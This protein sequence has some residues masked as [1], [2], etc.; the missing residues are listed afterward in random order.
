VPEAAATNRWLGSGSRLH[1]FQDLARF[2]VHDILLVASLYDAFILTEDGQPT[3]G[4]LGRFLSFEP[5][6]APRLRHAATGAEA[7]RLAATEGHFD[8]VIAGVQLGDM[9]VVELTRRLREAGQTMP[10]VALAYDASDLLGLPDDAGALDRVFLWQGD[11][12]ILPAI[13]KYVEDRLNVAADTGEMGVPAIILIEDSVRYYSSF[14]PVI[15][16]ELMRHARSLVPEGLNLS[17]KL[18]RQ[19][20][21]PKILLCRTFEEAW[22][23][24]TAYQDAILGV[25]ADIEFPKGGALA[26]EAGVE[27]ARRVRELQPDVPIMLQSS[28]PENASLAAAVPA[29]FLL[30]DSPTL[31][32]ELQRFMVD[33]FGFGEFIFRTADGTIVG[34]AADLRTLEAELHRVPAESLA[35]HG[36][37]NHFSKWLKARTEFAL[38]HRLRPRTVGDFASLEHLRRDLIAAIH[39]YRQRRR[40]GIVA[41]FDPATFDAETSFCRL[42]SGSLGG[43]GRGLAFLSFLL[44]EYGLPAR[45]APVDLG[46]PPAV[47]LGTD[48][49]DRVLDASDLRDAALASGDDRAVLDRLRATPLPDDV[50]RALARFLEVARY[51]LAVRSSSLL[52]DSPYQPFAGVY[53]T[54]MV[55]NRGDLGTRL[56]HLTEAIRRVYASTF[57]PRVRAYLAASPYRHEEE[58]MAVVIQRVAGR[59]RGDRYYPDLAGV[60]RSH[61]FYAVPPLTAHDGIAAVGLGL[62]ATVVGGDTCFRFSPKHPHHVIQF[63]SVRDVLQNSQRTFYALRLGGRDEGAADMTFDLEPY[64]LATAER[65][66]SLAAVG[67]TYSPENDA[68]FDGIARPGVRLVSFAP[69]LK[70]G[71]FPL[72]DLV[73]ELL[74]I[75]EQGVGGPVELEFAANLAGGGRP[76]EFA[77]LQV[78][79]LAF[80]RDTA[81]LALDVD[82]GST[83]LCRSDL[84]LGH[85]RVDD[86]RDL[87]V[88]DPS[89]VGA[90]RSQEIATEI[91]RLNAALVGAGRPYVLIAVGRL[92]SSEP[93]LGVPVV[94]DQIA[95]ARAIVEAGFRDFKVTPSQGSHFFQ[96]LMTFRVGYFTVN[97]EAGEGF[98]DWDW[99]AAQPAETTRAGVRH[100]RLD[101]PLSIRMNGQDHRGVMTVSATPRVAPAMA[102]RDD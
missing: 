32:H 75:S 62:G 39:E 30:K 4:V 58:K 91:G 26:P 97:P 96:H 63:S 23:D 33:N 29:S 87:V 17:D 27:F 80:S 44:E 99:L 13:V 100:L 53:D 14:L 74:T 49:F 16:T 21:R 93:T 11:V 89:R 82:A 2:R 45:F 36:E 83:L 94:W 7:V 76:A 84:V 52:E 31:L 54:V 72:A 34:R 95:G 25:I 71:L 101:A 19:Q 98:L 48:V 47:V 8:L 102:L 20:A 81:A 61:N 35:F 3:E 37:R 55:P 73:A 1:G 5:H 68:V 69:I 79:P 57:T 24:F 64:D 88:L 92:G 40:R 18:M 38:A 67:S 51:P 60:A 85:G 50:R 12:G 59:A 41:D 22:R 70:H 6:D 90:A 86:V 10:V 15:Y 78:R 66:G 56:A 77:L 43:K 65:D 46:V 9:G 28:L 42:G